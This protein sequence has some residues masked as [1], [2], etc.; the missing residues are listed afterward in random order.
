MN[1][2]LTVQ[3]ANFLDQQNWNYYCTFTTPYPMSINSARKA[4]ERFHNALTELNLKPLIFWVAEPFDTK[5]GYHTHALLKIEC[6]SINNNIEL[7]KTTWFMVT[8][9]TSFK[10]RN[11]GTHIRAYKKGE[12]AHFYVAKYLNRRDVL[13]NIL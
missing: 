6:N 8:R 10:S 3:Y 2:S 12:G 1:Q 4:M 7:I 5:Y 13:Y 9:N 11:N